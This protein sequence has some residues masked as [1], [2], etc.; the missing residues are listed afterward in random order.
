MSDLAEYRIECDFAI[1]RSPRDG[2][3]FYLDAL[4]LQQT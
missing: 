4:Q 3:V 2:C 1:D